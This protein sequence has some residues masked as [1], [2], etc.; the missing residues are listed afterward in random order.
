MVSFLNGA[1][2]DSLLEGFTITN[3]SGTL[4]PFG[5]FTGYSGGGILCRG[6]SPTIRGNVIAQSSLSGSFAN[7]GGGIFCNNG[8]LVV[9]RG[10]VVWG[11]SAASGA[12]IAVHDSASLTMHYSNV[13]GGLAAAYAASTA[14]LS[15]GTGMLELDPR[16]VDRA[17]GDFALNPGSPCIDVGDPATSRCLDRDLAGN[18][19]QLDGLL[20][21][22]MRIDMGAHRSSCHQ[23]S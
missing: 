23:V 7:G 12:Q 17:N 21:H 8:S 22:A 13:E 1:G 3:G 20:D 19:R 10:T 4:A 14:T 15:W 16:F 2:L 6:T 18:P 11:N 9:A 5:T